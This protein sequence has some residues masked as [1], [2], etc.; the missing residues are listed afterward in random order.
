MSLPPDLP[1]FEPY[2]PDPAFRSSVWRILIAMYLGA[3]VLV[4]V[5]GKVLGWW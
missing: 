5:V 3:F 4:A 1:D 2:E